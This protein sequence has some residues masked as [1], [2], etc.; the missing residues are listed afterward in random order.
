[1]ARKAFYETSTDK[2]G[3]VRFQLIAKGG[4]PMDQSEPYYD[5]ST[6]RRGIRRHAAAAAEAI[7]QP[8]RRRK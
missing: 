7:K 3:K 2:K 8:I 5:A 4:E 6:C 1:M